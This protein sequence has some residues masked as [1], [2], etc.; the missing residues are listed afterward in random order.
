M[1]LK[2]YIKILF[3]F[4]RWDAGKIKKIVVLWRELNENEL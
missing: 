4:N 1:P 3:S 2:F